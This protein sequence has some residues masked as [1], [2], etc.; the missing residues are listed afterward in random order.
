MSV[1]RVVSRDHNGCYTVCFD[2]TRAQCRRWIIGRHG[3]IPPFYA[4][5]VRSSDFHR[6]FE[7]SKRERSELEKA[8]QSLM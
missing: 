3:C 1:F 4:I 8:I 2:G 7:M 6:C 5:T